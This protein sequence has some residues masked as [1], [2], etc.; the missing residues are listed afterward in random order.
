MLPLGRLAQA[1]QQQIDVENI[2][3]YMLL[4]DEHLRS[5]T[6]VCKSCPK[7]AEH[8]KVVYFTDTSHFFTTV[9]LILEL[10]SSKSSELLQSWRSSSV[11]DASPVSI[12]T[13]RS[14]VDTTMT[15]LLAMPHFFRPNLQQVPTFEAC[16]RELCK[17]LL[18]FLKGS[19][20]R[21]SIG[22]RALAESL[23]ISIQPYLP[24][25]ET[26]G[27]INLSRKN[28]H[29]LDFL[30]SVAEAVGKRQS[31]YSNPSLDNEDDPMDVDDD[32][33]EFSQHSHGRL[34]TQ[35]SAIP[36]Q[37]LALD[38]S[39]ASF[40]F[41]V[42][43]RLL[44][45]ASMDLKQTAVTSIP[46]SF[47]EKLCA[48]HDEELLLN[49]YFVNELLRSD[50]T[51]ETDDATRL[52]ERVLFLLKAPDFDLCEVSLI[53]ALDCAIG[54]APL[55]L[56]AEAESELAEFA[57][58]FYYWL[59]ETA[60]KNMILSPELQK[61]SGELLLLLMKES[62]DYGTN[63]PLQ[64]ARSL[65][66]TLLERSELC[67]KWYIADHLPDIFQLFLLEDHD[68]I[69]VD[70]LEVLPSDSEWLEGMCF[71]VIALSKLASKW[72]T[73]QRRC[74][75]HIFEVPEKVS[76][77]L[78]HAVQCMSK[79]S[80]ALQLTNSRE[81]FALF[82][83]Q[84]LFTWLAADSGISNLPFE[85]FGFETLRDLISKHQ[86][87]ITGIMMMLGQ[88]DE[89]EVVIGLL[90]EEATNVFE[91]CFTKIIAYTVAYDL[92]V[93]PPSS[94]EKRYITGESRLKKRLGPEKFIQYLNNNFADIIALLF[95]I[96]D[97]HDSLDK[98]LLQKRNLQ[99]A[100]HIMS[101]IKTLTEN[102]AVLPPL[103]QPTFKAKKLSAQLDHLCTKTEFESS[104]IYTPALVVFVARKVSNTIHPALGSLHACAVLRK[105]RTLICFAG[106]S[107]TSGYPLEMLLQILQPYIKD[108]QCANDAIGI[109]QYLLETGIE[110]LSR[111]PNFVAG[112]SL[113]VFGSLKEIAKADRAS[114]T[115]ESQHKSTISRITTFHKW[116]GSYLRK[117]YMDMLPKSRSSSSLQRLFESAC[118][119]DWVG[120]ADLRTSE[121]DLLLRLLQDEH[122][123]QKLLDGPSREIALQ[124]LCNDFQ[125]PNSFRTDVLG[126]DK[127]SVANAIAVW[128]SCRS[129]I[130]NKKYLSWASR[131]LGRAFAASGVI[132]QD[133][134]RESS[135][136]QMKALTPKPSTSGSQAGIVDLLQE[137]TLGRN[138]DHIGLAE[139]A[140]RL[141]LSK[142]DDTVVQT[143]RDCISPG[144]YDASIWAPLTVPPSDVWDDDDL[145]RVVENCYDEHGIQ[146]ENWVR[147]LTVT[148]A[149]SV[150]SDDLLN[151]VVPV[152]GSVVGF[153]EKAFPFIIHLV[154][155]TQL[156]DQQ[157]MKRKLSASF[158]TWFDRSETI[159]KNNLKVLI[160]ALLYL[161][162]QPPKDDR[163]SGNRLQWLSIDY[164]KAATAATHCG[165][166]KTALLFIEEHY[167][168]PLKS[169]R[170]SSFKDGLEQ[171]EMPVDILLDVFQ[172]I[173]D[174]D[175]YYGVQQTSNL[176]TILARFEYEKDG[177][178]SLA[179]RGAQFDSHIRRG[180]SEADKDAQSLVKAL[181]VLSL[182]GLSHS[183]LQAQ[184]SVDMSASSI[185]SMY[186]TARK[187]EQWDI[188][189]PDVSSNNSIA[190]YKAF[191]AINIADD[192]ASIRDALDESFN[193]TMSALVSKDL[194][195]SDLHSSLQTLAALVE[196][197]EIFS[198]RGSEQIEEMLTR[199]EARSNWMKTGR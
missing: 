156:Q 171:H 10:I 170:R 81:L 161:R 87:E 5:S 106:K 143:F 30:I 77:S 113:S 75:Y 68:A 115:Q 86:D 132:E 33:K 11:D 47:I 67:V 89:I 83:P 99:P 189:V 7:V 196:M 119:I 159:N 71:R 40:E 39:S 45:V 29:L 3:R 58:D 103:T 25:C 55:W 43:S 110:H 186:Q 134:L 122:K 121:S 117:Q 37:L 42:A 183:L 34:D 150:S 187:L 104:D 125:A 44:L 172:S 93:P 177:P 133:L 176:S 136:S 23:V 145:L 13:F 9:K 101:R 4:L 36:R 96:S 116:F 73:L 179:F 38:A 194:G 18:D 100:G 167:S 163:P 85:I 126:D 66:F 57:M 184:Q 102:R 139:S 162:T 46:R 149:R 50:M 112:I 20:N 52:L 12:D 158:N 2:V 118:T 16:V 199:F 60:L 166:H 130:S 137:L 26:H 141:A 56:T 123:S 180:D 111:V 152:L 92:S 69:F 94:S 97:P 76:E 129:G 51:L 14:A 79:V 35:T 59:A 91:S 164:M 185:E 95:T 124:M 165:M 131:V 154:L 90:G 160:N 190:V 28:P 174:P 17:E 22:A 80:S 88:D 182:S 98:Y 31:L 54:L 146:H 168:T 155:S 64:S 142:S 61:R 105:I 109:M 195:V 84:I 72:P 197:D 27:F 53:L 191:Q 175:M 135:L 148:L 19:D 192:H 198:T 62:P 181:D 24:P 128:K 153:A 78:G 6:T 21:D 178:K 48:M 140:L 193:C 70:I 173:E 15:M 32:F 49:H 1:W 41:V 108:A 63:I 151:A 157:S 147:N 82:A 120:N 138:K 114:S 144:L 169:S 107:V 8:D 74:I 65:L 127:A 188:P